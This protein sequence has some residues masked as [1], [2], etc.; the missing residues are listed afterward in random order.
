MVALPAKYLL[1]WTIH[2]IA[3]TCQTLRHFSLVTGFGIKDVAVF[4]PV[5]S[6]A[7]GH[8]ILNLYSAY[9]EKYQQESCDDRSENTG[10]GSGV[11][12]FL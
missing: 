10:F 7:L 8:N 4:E 1:Q 6:M 2:G 11:F 12:V 5:W 9:E 3:S